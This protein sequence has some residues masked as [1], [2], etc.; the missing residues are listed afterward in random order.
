LKRIATRI[1]RATRRRSRASASLLGLLTGGVMVALSACATMP[2]LPPPSVDVSGDWV[3]TWLAFQ[4]R[5]GS[6]DMKG[7]FLQ[8]GTTL[9]GEF[10][11]RNPKVNRTYV[12]GMVTGNEIKLFAPEEG[13]LVVNGDEMTGTFAGIVR[14]Q[15]HLRR[16]SWQPPPRQ[17]SP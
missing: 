16:E 17:Q 11:I 6:G 2:P 4:G 3:G 12:S 14:G 7:T 1:M 9:H 15:I 13:S 5:G 8:D 10:E